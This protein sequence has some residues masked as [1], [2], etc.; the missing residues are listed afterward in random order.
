MKAIAHRS[1]TNNEIAEYIGKDPNYVAAYLPRLVDNEIIEKRESFNKSQKMNYYEISDNLI[2][3]WYRFIFDNRE[4]ILQNMG[5]FIYEESLDEIALFISTGFEDVALSYLTEKNVKASLAIITRS[6]A[7][8]RSIT[9]SWDVP[10]SLT[11]WQK[12]SARQRIVCLL[13][14]ANIVI[15]HCRLRYWIT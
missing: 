14:S 11:A 1:R 3:F 9:Q 4:E 12:V 6:F 8:I 5:R 2:R 15:K 13:P 7:D 10:S